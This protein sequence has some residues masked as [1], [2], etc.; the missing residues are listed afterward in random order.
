MKLRILS[1][2]HL[3]IN[4]KYPL[5]IPNNYDFTLIAGDLG[6]EYRKN[7]EWIRKNVHRGAFIS[8]NHDAYTFDYTPL[9]D[10]KEFYHKEFP[11]ESEVTYFDYDV[12][13][14]SKE[15]DDGLLLVAD[16]LYTDYATPCYDYE[17]GTDL[18]QLVEWNISRATP[19]MS[20]SFM[21]DF[22]YATRSREFS[23]HEHIHNKELRYISPRQYLG[24]FN[25]AFEKIN[26][27]VET[28]GDKEII[29]MTHHCLSPRCC[30]GWMDKESLLASYVSNKEDWIKS[31]ENIK[32]IVSGHIHNVMEFNIG[33]A[34][35]VMNPLGYCREEHDITNNWTQDYFVDTKTWKTEKIPY[36]NDW[37]KQHKKENDLFLRHL[38]FFN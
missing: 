2:L 5:E 8:G 35:Y 6:P 16:V 34:L 23:T 37:E 32:L 12:G 38:A 36:N 33:N 25:K 27:I 10:V 29:L 1:D 11:L 13:V 22:K 3:S 31:H 19:K 18:K 30:S 20:G 15:I 9:E 4:H 21:N 17:K 7:A 28:N 14:V 24:H 26:E